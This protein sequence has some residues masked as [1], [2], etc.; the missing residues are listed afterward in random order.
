MVI[1]WKSPEYHYY[2]KSWVWYVTAMAIVAFLLIVTIWQENFL[3]AVFVIVAG[4]MVIVWG[5]RRPKLI[6][7][8][9]DEKRLMIV[10][11]EYELKD[12]AGFYL[13]KKLLVFKTKGRFGSFVKVGVSE[14][15]FDKI[16]KELQ[17]KMPEVEYEESLTDVFSH[18]LGF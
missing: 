7:C 13:E 10:D 9:L 15:V 1:K 2:E 8:E 4:V 12:F 17:K 6:R 11:K 14:D 3:F 18:W 5:R 16:N